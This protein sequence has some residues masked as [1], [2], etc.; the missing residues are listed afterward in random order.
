[1]EI[2]FHNSDKHAK[3]EICPYVSLFVLY[4]ELHV[5]PCPSNTEGS[6]AEGRVCREQ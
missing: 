6:G 5:F 3:V 1:M 2:V 4:P